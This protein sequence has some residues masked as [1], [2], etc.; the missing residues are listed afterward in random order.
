[1]QIYNEYIKYDTEAKVNCAVVACR[2]YFFRFFDILR[3][4]YGLNQSSK[5]GNIYLSNGNE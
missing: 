4:V 1:M 2:T 3:Q 5:Q